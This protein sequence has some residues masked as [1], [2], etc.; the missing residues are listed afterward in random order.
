MREDDRGL[1]GVGHLNLN[2]PCGQKAYT[3]AQQGVLVDFSIGFRSLDDHN[4]TIQTAQGEVEVRVIT[5]ARIFE[6][7]LVEEPMNKD[8]Q[9]TGVKSQDVIGAEELREMTPR[10]LE[11][12]LEACGMFSRKA[13]RIMV[14]ELKSVLT[15]P[16]MSTGEMEDQSTLK[17]I[18]A[19]LGTA[20]SS[21]ADSAA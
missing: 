2:H 6:G 1:F 7:S 13:V 3:L 11:D 14:T 20:R 17:Q 15:T 10:E 8:A 9:V 5:K 16:G 4:E 21:I 12:M 19:D 18:L